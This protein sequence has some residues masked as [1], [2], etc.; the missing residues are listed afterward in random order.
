MDDLK[1]YVI[2]IQGAEAKFQMFEY[3][4]KHLYY[5]TKLILIFKNKLQNK[6]IDTKQ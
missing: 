3:T 1:D 5:E 2:D 6:K 4:N